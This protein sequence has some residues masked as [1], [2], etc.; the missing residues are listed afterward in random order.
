MTTFAKAFKP[1]TKAEHDGYM[2][3]DRVQLRK[4][5]EGTIK[6]IGR[7]KDK[8][9]LWFGLELT[10]SHIGKHNGTLDNVEYYKCRSHKGL[11]VQS[12][13]ILRKKG[14]TTNPKFGSK[15]RS[16]TSSSSTSTS[17]LPMSSR[18]SSK[19][20]SQSNQS[21]H[22]AAIPTMP[23]GTRHSRKHKRTEST[24][25]QIG[26]GDLNKKIKKKKGV[27]SKKISVPDVSVCDHSDTLF[28]CIFPVYF[29]QRETD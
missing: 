4:K 18:T 26:T 28:S 3:H 15:S 29:P 1:R 9:G 10:S 21:A 20:S 5:R 22:S 25:T 14:V 8:R 2:L 19:I 24:P 13:D 23:S 11:F 6:Y 17:P 12:K 7:V 27:S 16:T